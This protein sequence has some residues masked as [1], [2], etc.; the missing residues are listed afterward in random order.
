MLRICWKWSTFW[1]ACNKQNTWEC[2]MCRGCNQ[3][4]SITDSAGPRSWSGDSKHYCI[5]DLDAGSWHEM[6]HA[7]GSCLVLHAWRSC[8]KVTA[9]DNPNR[10]FCRVFWTVEEILG[11][12]CEV[13]RCLLWRGLRCHCPKYNVSCILYL[14]QKKSLFFIVHGQILS[15]QTYYI[16]IEWWECFRD[17]RWPRGRKS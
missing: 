2:W 17:Y 3:Q 10:G 15:G 9:D 6:C 8:G 14:L 11:E 13:P 12:L 7:K 5:W 1:K 4:R 16:R